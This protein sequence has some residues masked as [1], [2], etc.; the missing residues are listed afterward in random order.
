MNKEN[1]FEV[2]VRSKL[3]FP[4]KGMVSVEDLWDLSVKNLDEIFKTLNSQI[5]LVKEDSLLNT[6]SK[7]DKILEL[8]IDIVKYIVQVKLDEEKQ[9]VKS[10]ENKQKKEKI[11]S[12]LSVK[13]DEDLQNKSPDE[14]QAM[15][16]ELDK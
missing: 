5:K 4:L 8:K 3:R 16:E 12:I 7:E 1:M 13:Q 10:L 9:R 6:K 2:A 14:L 11:L 15:L